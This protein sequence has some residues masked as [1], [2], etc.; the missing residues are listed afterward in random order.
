MVIS[1]SNDIAWSEL[2]GED[3]VITF[4]GRRRKRPDCT[5]WCNRGRGQSKEFDVKIEEIDRMRPSKSNLEP[6]VDKSGF[7]SVRS[8]QQAIRSLNREM[9]DQ[10]WLYRVSRVNDLQQTP[11]V[12]RSD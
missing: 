3:E 5:T 12:A 6:Y 7:D 2:V 9:P 8:W 1:F 11:L 4:R 10:G